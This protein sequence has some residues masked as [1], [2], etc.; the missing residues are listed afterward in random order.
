MSNVRYVICLILASLL[1][2][3]T[4]VKAQFMAHGFWQGS[5]GWTWMSGSSFIKNAHHGT[6]GTGS[7]SNFPGARNNSCTWTDS[8]GNFWLFG[9]QGYEQG[10][11][12]NPSAGLLGDL[13]RYEPANGK[14]TWMKGSDGAYESPTF[15]TKGTAAAG[16]VPGARQK[17]SCWIDASNNL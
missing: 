15:G 4:P 12:G 8:T 9:G 5:T 3:T 17:S 13:W 7:T 16:N 6:L 1:A 11:T 2:L 10:N 14:W